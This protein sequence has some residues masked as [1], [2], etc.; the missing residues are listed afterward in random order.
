M[1]RKK[2]MELPD[3]ATLTAEQCSG[4]V[5]IRLSEAT[6]APV[7]FADPKYS[8]VLTFNHMVLGLASELGEYR[9]G[10]WGYLQVSDN[11]ERADL[12]ASKK[13]NLV[14]ELGDIMWYVAGA[15]RTISLG[16][17]YRL[18]GLLVRPWTLDPSEATGDLDAPVSVIGNLAD[19]AKRSLFYVNTTT[20]S[21]L[22]TF[23][24]TEQH[25]LVVQELECLVDWV[26]NE[27]FYQ[28]GLALPSVM[29]ANIRKLQGKGGRFA[30]KFEACRALHR[31]TKSEME[32][33]G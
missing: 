6:V 3:P 28:H 26:A 32:A 9:A 8:R 22:E 24:T 10:W 25:G 2:L 11:H 5:Y 18:Q 4:D 13:Q 31:N 1:H 33:H 23:P 17:P 20:L 12:V 16:D 7:L 15:L 21:S 14:E 27:A 19:V 29:A 30:E